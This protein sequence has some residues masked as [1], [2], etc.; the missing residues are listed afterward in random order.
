MYYAL[1]LTAQG[2]NAPAFYSITPT[3]N[4][5][6]SQGGATLAPSSPSSSGIVVN[7]Y[8]QTMQLSAPAGLVSA[9]VTIVT[10]E[11]R[12]SGRVMVSPAIT[13]ATVVT[14]YGNGGKELGQITIDPGVGSG[15]FDWPVLP[16]S[17]FAGAE[18][19]QQFIATKIGSPEPPQ[20]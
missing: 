10:N 16:G 1:T 6:I 7:I 17:N 14:L 5:T 11:P 2:T 4:L 15:T 18:E 3:S 19:A 13:V 20:Y 12:V 8:P 9:G